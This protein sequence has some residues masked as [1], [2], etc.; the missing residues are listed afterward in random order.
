MLVEPNEIA[1]STLTRQQFRRFFQPSRIVLGILKSPARSGVNLITLCFDMYC[2]YKPPMMAFSIQTG[3]YSYGLL[4]HAE[5][6]VLAVPGERLA[7]ETLFCGLNSARDIDKVRECAIPL[8]ESQL[9][10]VPAISTAI[11][12]IELRLV[13]KIRTGDHQ[14][15]IGE[16][17]RFAV[18]QQN[19]ERCL[20][21]I[22][23]NVTGYRVL[24]Q[25]GIHRVAVVDST[26]SV[27]GVSA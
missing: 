20:L 24:A 9:V 11:A 5:E 2:S 12:N 1:F 13:Q 21:S 23:P 7:E 27:G 8:T 14:T 25:H 15:A 26:V 4:E 6:C 10:K 18:N 16:V 22:G 17:L 3:A 19:S